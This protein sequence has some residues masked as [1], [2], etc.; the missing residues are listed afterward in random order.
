MNVREIAKRIRT[1]FYKWLDDIKIKILRLWLSATSSFVR[2]WFGIREY[3]YRALGLSVLIVIFY[4]LY[5]HHSGIAGHLEALNTA[6]SGMYSNLFIAIGAA[7]VGVIAITFS[8]SLFAVQQAADK[9]TPS[10]LQGFLKDKTNRNIF[11]CIVGIALAFFLFAVFPTNNVIFYEI[12]C[13]FFLLILTFMLLQKQYYHV[14]K[15]VNP[16]YQ[17]ILHHN[18]AIKGLEKIDKWLDLMIKI[19]AIQPGPENEKSNT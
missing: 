17:I 19:G 11:W 6:N 14:T 7:I 18:E 13:A 15:L 10:I 8:L 16:N 12:V 4:L 1:N 9:H 5:V 2:V 3:L